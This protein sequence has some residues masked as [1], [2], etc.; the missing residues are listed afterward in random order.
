MRELIRVGG[1]S[2]LAR[3]GL[4]LAL[5]FLAVA[6]TCE[7]AA[8]A[9]CPNTA[10]PTADYLCPL[11]P[12]YVIPGLADIGGWDQASHYQNILYGDLTGHGT[13]EMVARGPEGIEVYRFDHA[14]GQWTQARGTADPARPESMERA[15]VLPHDGAG[16]HRR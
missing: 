9:S 8:A 13:D 1:F 6:V 12:K 15:A 5:T 4:A 7:S 14:L 11:G 10:D 3:V 2:R 16:R